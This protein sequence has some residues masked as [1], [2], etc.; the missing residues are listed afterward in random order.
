MSKVPNVS[1]TVNNNLCTG[2][3]ICEG[4]CPSS[5]ISI[6]PQHGVFSPVIN[7]LTCSNDKGCHRCYD[8]CPGIGIKL[9]E[10]ADNYFDS[11][12]IQLDEH[13]GK[14]LKC[15]SGYSNDNEIRYHSASGGMVTQFLI[16]LLEKKYID[17]AL[18]TAF[19]SKNEFLVNSY[20]AKTKEELLAAKSSKYAPVTFNKAIQDIKKDNSKNIIIVGLPCHI[21]GFRK[22]ETIDKGFKEK[23]SGYFGIYCSSG[24][25]FNMTEYIFKTRKLSLNNISYFSYRDDGCL[26]SMKV[27]HNNSK[28]CYKEKYT[29]YYKLRSIFVPHR[30]LSCIDH[31]NELSDV[32]FGDVHIPPYSEDKI[33]VNSIVTR[34][35]FF[36]DLLKKAAKEGII[37]LNLLEKK[38]LLASQPMVFKKK[39][40]N[41]TFIKID[42]LLGLKTPE[43]DYKL[44]DKHKNKSVISYFHTI[45]QIFV[46]SHKRLWFTIPLIKNK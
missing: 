15:Y 29:S 1:Y 35:L 3:G 40:R 36:D 18:V 43:Y 20:I 13:I 25:T 32:S 46:G 19:D 37:T 26:G 8:S 11:S 6:K 39:G 4:A 31:F 5:S 38:V 23:I 14:Y 10:K 33:G 34:T 7:E 9:Y 27:M 41:S 24:R 2:C 12:N 42:K 17:G 16:W 22:Y 21:H 30:C 44:N 28:K 45:V